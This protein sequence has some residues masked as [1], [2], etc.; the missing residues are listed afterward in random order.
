[1]N[2]VHDQCPNSDSETVLSPKNGSKLSQVH[3]AP[4]LAQPAST[5]APRR[6]PAHAVSWRPRCRV[7]APPLDRVAGKAAMSWPSASC[8]HGRV[9]ACLATQAALSPAPTYHNTLWCI[10]IQMPSSLTLAC[11][12]TISCIMT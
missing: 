11:H 8:R 9:V 10:A 1:M 2:S 6:A 4:N 5:G 3:S 12:D 7:V